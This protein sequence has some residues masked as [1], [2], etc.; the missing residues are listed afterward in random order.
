MRVEDA[1]RDGNVRE[2]ESAMAELRSLAR[3]L[4]TPPEEEAAMTL[5]AP[6]RRDLD[7]VGPAVE[8]WAQAKLGPDAHVSAASSPGNGMSSETVLFEMTVDGETER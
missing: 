8:K 6:W 5:D 2:L 7:E 4:E 1:A 3:R